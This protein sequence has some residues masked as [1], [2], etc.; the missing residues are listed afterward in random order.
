MQM[1]VLLAHLLLI[2]IAPNNVSP[3]VTEFSIVTKCLLT[4]PSPIPFCID[5]SRHCAKPK[6]IQARPKLSVDIGSASA[7]LEHPDNSAF[8]VIEAAV[9]GKKNKQKRIIKKKKWAHN[10]VQRL[11]MSKR[12]GKHSK[13]YRTLNTLSF[14][15]KYYFKP[16]GTVDSKTSVCFFFFFKRFHAIQ[17]VQI[18]DV[19]KR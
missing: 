19:A 8:S 15:T 3:C 11:R 1:Q 4:I 14:N 17:P 7:N 12:T 10:R 13:M 6:S 5:V 18:P 9:N 2:V 16:F